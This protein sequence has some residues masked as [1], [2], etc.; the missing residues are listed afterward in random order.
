MLRFCI[1][2][3]LNIFPGTVMP[4]LYHPDIWDLVSVNWNSLCKLCV[5][6]CVCVRVCVF[7]VSSAITIT[8]FCS[9]CSCPILLGY[10]FCSFKV[11][12]SLFGGR[13]QGHAMTRLTLNSLW[14]PSWPW[15]CASPVPASWV[16]DYRQVP[17]HPV[18]FFR[19][20]LYFG[21]LLLLYPDAYRLILSY[22]QRTS[23]LSKVI[24]HFVLL[25]SLM[26][27]SFLGL[28]ISLLLCLYFCQW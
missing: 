22:V 6:V 19:C 21:K 1:L 28:L 24:L 3:V 9:L 13:R 2:S 4:S 25:L 18:G 15:T 10:S 5:C 23:E 11:L 16:L 8:G 12:H 27:I 20:A 17:T 14:S 26:P 7:S